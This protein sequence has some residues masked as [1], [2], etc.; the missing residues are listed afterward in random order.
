MRQIGAF[1]S[2]KMISTEECVLEA[3]KLSNLTIG[4]RG[5][6]I[7]SRLNSVVEKRADDETYDLRKC[8]AFEVVT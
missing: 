7:L 6:K 5:V 8:Q 4:T 2:L 3:P 1:R